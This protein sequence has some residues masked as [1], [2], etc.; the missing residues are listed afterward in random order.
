MVLMNNVQEDCMNYHV[1]CA[2]E[3]ASNPE[4]AA[5]TFH[6]LGQGRHFFH[7]NWC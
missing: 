5:F 4:C 6:I 1:Q 3:C 7:S 2:N